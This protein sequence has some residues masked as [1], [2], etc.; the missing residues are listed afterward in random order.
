MG[1]HPTDVD[2][3][4]G[5]IWLLHCCDLYELLEQNGS[6]HQVFTEAQLCHHP[7]L[8]L[9]EAP[10]EALQV[11]RDGAGELVPAEHVVDE[12]HL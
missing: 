1:K 9:I 3:A 4:Q 12:L 7:V 10:H 8:H 2:R 11:S 5:Q 6:F